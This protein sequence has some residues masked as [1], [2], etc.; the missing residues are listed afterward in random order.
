MP[1]RRDGVDTTSMTIAPGLIQP[2][3]PSQNLGLS[4]A[5][6]SSSTGWRSLEGAQRHAGTPASGAIAQHSPGRS[7]RQQ[8]AQSG[9]AA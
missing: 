9:C 2:P 3:G 6:P 5:A 8:S 1:L 4:I 7:E